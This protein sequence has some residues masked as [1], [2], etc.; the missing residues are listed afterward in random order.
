MWSHT[1][2]NYSG[3]GSLVGALAARLLLCNERSSVDDTITMDGKY[4]AV[5]YLCF[6]LL[7]FRLYYPKN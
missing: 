3:H 7:Q 1:P 2:K 5:F 6:S 4:D